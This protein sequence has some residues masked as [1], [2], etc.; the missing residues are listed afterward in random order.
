MINRPGVK[1]QCENCNTL[2]NAW[3]L[4]FDDELVKDLVICAYQI[5]LETLANTGD[6][7]RKFNNTNHLYY[8]NKRNMTEDIFIA[9]QYLSGAQTGAFIW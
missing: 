5:I 8:T 4:F 9:L 7:R 3:A 2:E 1:T 6:S